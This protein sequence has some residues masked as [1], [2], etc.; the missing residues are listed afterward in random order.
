LSTG[1]FV[2]FKGTPGTGGKK[3]SKILTLPVHIFVAL[4]FCQF[5]KVLLKQMQEQKGAQLIAKRKKE[6]SK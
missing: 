5:R 6:R 3:P 2:R 4:K 1:P